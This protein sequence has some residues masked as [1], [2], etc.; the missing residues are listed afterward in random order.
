[1]TTRVQPVSRHVPE[2]RRGPPQHQHLGVRGRVA[3][4]LAL[5]AGRGQH[6]P[7]GSSSTAPTG[8]S[9]CC[10]RQ[11]GLGPA[12]AA[13]TRPAARA[14]CGHDRTA[15]ELSGRLGHPAELGVEVDLVGDLDEH[16]VAAQVEVLDDR[17]QVEVA[18]ARGRRRCRGRPSARCPRRRGRG[19]P[20]RAGRP[21]RGRSA[22]RPP[23]AASESSTWTCWPRTRTI[24]NTSSTRLTK[25]I[26]PASPGSRRSWAISSSRSLARS[27]LERLDHATGP[28]RGRPR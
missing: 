26:A 17:A 28:P 2:R 5:V 16:L 24:T 15:Q 8:T 4:E 19:C 9:P 21:R 11:P 18:H 7:S 1:M 12:P 23:R 25:P 10:S 20:R 3:R 27:L 14:R 13:S 6:L 22:S